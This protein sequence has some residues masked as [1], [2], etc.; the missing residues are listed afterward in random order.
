MGEQ[1][2]KSL[3]GKERLDV[4]FAG[5]EK[6]KPASQA[7]VTLVLEDVAPE[8]RPEGLS[9]QSEIAIT[10]ILKRSGASEYR[11]N[12]APCR[13]RDIKMLFLGTGLGNKN[14][15]AL[16]EQGRVSAFIQSTPEQR[17]LWI[18]EAAGISRYKEHRKQAE[19]SL[20]STQ[21]NLD[22]LNDI[23]RELTQQRKSL[24]RQATRAR[25]H[26][27]LRKEIEEL[28]LYLAAHRYLE[29]W[30]RDR[31]IQLLLDDL[32]EVEGTLR[33]SIEQ[34][35]A[36]C[37]ASEQSRKEEAEAIQAKREKLQRDLAR[38]AL[39]EQSAQHLQSDMGGFKE[40]KSQLTNEKDKLAQ[41]SQQ[42][43]DQLSLI[44]EH[45]EQLQSEDGDAHSSLEQLSSE[46]DELNERLSEADAVID[47][48]KGDV[49]EAVTQETTARNHAHELGRR[50]QDLEQ[51]LQRFQADIDEAAA[52]DATTQAQLLQN[53]EDTEKNREAQEQILY[54]QED[55]Q[56][57]KEALKDQIDQQRLHLQSTQ[58]LLAERR[59]RLESLEEIQAQ[60][61]DLNEASRALL[62]AR[63]TDGPLDHAQLHGVVADLVEIPKAYEIPIAATLGDRLQYLVLDQERDVIEAIAYLDEQGCGRAGFITLPR[64]VATPSDTLPHDSALRGFLIDLIGEEERSPL[65]T[66]LLRS[67]V[68][69][70]DLQ[71]A[72]RL[73]PI[74]PASLTLATEAGEILSA[75]GAIL[76]GSQRSAGLGMIQR[77]REIRELSEKVAILEEAA[78]QAEHTLADQEYLYEQL[79][80]QSSQYREQLQQIALRQTKLLADQE[81]LENEAQRHQERLQRLRLE[82]QRLQ[83]EQENLSEAQAEAQKALALYEEERQRHEKRLQQARFQIEADRQRQTILSR[84][85]TDLK[86]QIATQQERL[87]A[88]QQQRYNLD[89]RKLH[90]QRRHIEIDAETAILDDKM[91]QK[92]Q[93]HEQ[94]QT[95]I[96][97]LREAVHA[98]EIQIRTQHQAHLAQEE[99]Y[100]HLRKHIEQ[101]R[102]Q[103]ESNREERTKLLLD[104][105]EIE[106]NRKALNEDIRLRYGITAGEA[107]Q[108]NHCTPRPQP[109]DQKRLKDLQTQLQRLGEVNPLAEKEYEEID[110]RFQFLSEQI[111][112]LDKAVAAIKQTIRKLDHQ[113]R[114]EFSSTFDAIRDHFAVLFP[115]I[116]EGGSAELILTEPNNLLETGVE[117]MVRPPGKRRQTVALLSGGEKAMTTIALLFA[118]FLYKPSPFCVLDEVDAPLDDVNIDRYNNVL[119]ELSQLTQ[120]IVITHN[121]RTMEMTDHLYGVTMQEPGVSTVLAVR[122]EEQRQQAAIPRASAR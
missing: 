22:R 80:L 24:Q 103:L 104:R 29:Y 14:S 101:Q 44:L 118:F 99:R 37:E 17:R 109:S 77:K 65:L 33:E 51:R 93:D 64:Q 59:A 71:A 43:T 54:A 89:A 121:K 38:V 106:V 75:D 98:D 34:H 105:R 4:I 110:E 25:R 92:L 55:L 9:E 56:A 69:V 115:K 6:R 30:A 72:L 100:A 119:R 86:V 23:L 87:E 74:L 122:L 12:G 21:G 28:D 114:D 19:S 36:D 83:Y 52:Q 2:I 32:S 53:I 41:Q 68:L 88:L 40:R 10:R 48:M 90:I 58:Q 82:Q 47:A 18:E 84:Q 20:N 61:N 79:T 57:R 63:T 60:Y 5:S 96:Q 15:Y 62:M 35:E 117:I 94:I 76:G 45:I 66:H 7:S 107:L 11:A 81:R 46:L 97:Q 31:Q 108:G 42:N 120:F 26:R 13:L 102:R 85:C 27:L 39:L 73:R 16:L 113:I 78:S 70:S 8:Y 116:F 50:Q 3:R 91:N 67:T 95:E 49:I 111:A 1:S 112:D